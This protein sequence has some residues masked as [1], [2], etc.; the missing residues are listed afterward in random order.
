MGIAQLSADDESLQEILR[1]ARIED[2]VGEALSRM[3]HSLTPS[4]APLLPSILWSAEVLD[5]ELDKSFSE[6][7]LSLVTNNYRQISFASK[8]LLS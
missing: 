5:F 6:K 8:V 4:Y 1:L 7:A 3:Q 2:K